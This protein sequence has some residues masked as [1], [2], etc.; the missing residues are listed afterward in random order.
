[1]PRATIDFRGDAWEVTY[2]VHEDPTVN[3]LGVSWGFVG[4]DNDQIEGL[5]ITEAEAL[6]VER[7]LID[8]YYDELPASDMADMLE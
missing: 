5:R 3:F 4:L 2:E 6:E 7:Q 8:I 1:M